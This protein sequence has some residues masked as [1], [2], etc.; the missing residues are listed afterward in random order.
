MTAFKSVLQAVVAA[1]SAQPRIAHGV[2]ANPRRIVPEQLPT[3][4]AVQLARSERDTKTLGISRWR[5]PVVVEC[6]ARGGNVDA[7][8]ER[9]WQRLLGLDSSL[10]AAGIEGVELLGIDWAYDEGRTDTECAAL[11]LLVQHQTLTD[12][13]QPRA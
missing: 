8:V 3:Y 2:E 4:V 6:Y 5:T 11:Q 9:A 13:L 1:L 12:S 7:L 10:N